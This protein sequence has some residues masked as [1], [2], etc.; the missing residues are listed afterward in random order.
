MKPFTVLG[1]SA[2]DEVF[3]PACLKSTTGL[4]PSDT[5][6]NGRPILPLYAADTTVQEERCTYCGSSLLELKAASEAQRDKA[7]PAF[8]VEKTR[9]HGGRPALRFDRKPPEEIRAELRRAGW[10]WDPVARLWWWPRGAP[11]PVPASLNL[12]SPAAKVL[13][14]QP[15]VRRGAARAQA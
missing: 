4:G 15:I 10:R 11:V 13:A 7:T 8:Q 2:N 9:H 12:P 6:Y 14:R 5:D 3:C 1:Y